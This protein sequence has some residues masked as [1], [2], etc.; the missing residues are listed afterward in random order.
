MDLLGLKYICGLP[1]YGYKAYK[2]NPYWIELVTRGQLLKAGYETLPTNRDRNSLELTWEGTS[3]VRNKPEDDVYY[4]YCDQ[5]SL[6]EKTKVMLDLGVN[7][8]SL[9]HMFGFKDSR[10]KVYNNPW[11]SDEMIANINSMNPTNNEIIIEDPV[12]T[13]IEEPIVVEEPVIEEPIAVKPDITNTEMEIIVFTGKN[14]RGNSKKYA[15]GQYNLH[16]DALIKPNTIKE[17]RIE[18]KGKLIMYDG[19]FENPIY[20]FENK[21]DARQYIQL[22]EEANKVDSFVITGL[23]ETVVPAPEQTPELIPEPTPEPTP[24]PVEDDEDD[25]EIEDEE[26]QEEIEIIRNELESI[27][28]RINELLDEM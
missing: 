1:N 6:E 4:F 10:D 11:W 17:I 18:G 9:W 15:S 14:M 5:K 13:P 23:T 7:K 24:E 27:R 2:S 20:T 25:E 3:T 8:F 16:N 26:D 21:Q 12:I 22:G 28:D 19:V